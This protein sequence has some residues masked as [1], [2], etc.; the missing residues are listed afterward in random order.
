MP[1]VAGI[2]SSPSTT[3]VV[4]CDALSGKVLRRAAVG[5]AAGGDDPHEWWNALVK[6]CDG[7]IL[8]GVQAIAVAGQRQSLVTVDSAGVVVRPALMSTDYRSATSADDLVI[9]GGGAAAW[10][11]AVGSVPTASFPI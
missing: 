10:A 7:G 2:D 1:I 6:A 4:V 3:R 11:A 5:H 9:E 8:D